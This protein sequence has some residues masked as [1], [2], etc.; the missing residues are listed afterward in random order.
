MIPGSEQVIIINNFGELSRLYS[1]GT[2]IFCG[3]SLVPLGGQNP[4]EAAAW[5]K[6]VFYGPYMDDFLDAK[7]ILEENNAGI[8]VSDPEM[9]AEKALEFLK[10]PELLKEYGTRARQAVR[11]NQGAAERH[12]RVIADL[13]R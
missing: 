9:L 13:V 5:G 7:A 4:L 1:V 2:I 10:D 3:A 11:Q 6:A 12:A 8:Q